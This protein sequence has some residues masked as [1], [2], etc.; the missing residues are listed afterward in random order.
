MRNKLTYLVV[1]TAFLLLF[2]HGTA[3]ADCYTNCDADYNS[4]NHNCPLCPCYEIYQVCFDSC[5][6]R[7]TDGDG[8]VDSIDNCSDYPNSNQADCDNDGTGNACDAENARYVRVSSQR[9]LIDKDT[10][11]PPNYYYDLEDWFDGV[12]VDQSS[13]G[14]PQK[15]QRFKNN[16]AHCYNVSP[17]D[18]CRQ[19]IVNDTFWCYNIGR[20]FC[21]GR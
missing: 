21:Q 10:H 6:Y 7:D 15:I 8:I 5:Q 16:E 2:S 1:L 4:C 3:K 9:C 18:C 11:I 13:C 17:K 20:N 14:A 19:L 12:Y